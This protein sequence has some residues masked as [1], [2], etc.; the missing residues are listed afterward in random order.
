MT[1][2]EC[3]AYCCRMDAERVERR[4]PTVQEGEMGQEEGNGRKGMAVSEKRCQ[5]D[6][7]FPLRSN[8]YSRVK[9]HF[10]TPPQPTK[11]ILNFA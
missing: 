8:Y 5:V 1:M 2:T 7:L 9:L 6:A 11:L 10:A 4:P 3:E